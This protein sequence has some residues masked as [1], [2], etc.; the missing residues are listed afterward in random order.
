M[1]SD[2]VT[3]IFGALNKGSFRYIV[4]RNYEKYPFE[5]GNDIDILLHADDSIAAIKASKEVFKAHS[6][7]FERLPITVNGFLLKG[8]GGNGEALVIHFQYW[9]SLEYTY[10]HC[11]LPGLSHKI[12]AQDV[13]P[14]HRV[15]NDCAFYIGS[16]VDRF[17]LLLRQWLFKRKT[18]YR[19]EVLNLQHSYGVNEFL[20]AS[21]IKLPIEKSAF[22]S[23]RFV[24]RFLRKIAKKRWGHSPFWHRYFKAFLMV[25]RFKK[26]SLFA[27]VIY[28]TGPDGAGKTSVSSILSS[29]FS[30]Q[31]V[32]VKH[33]YSVKRNLIRH[34]VFTIRRRLSGRKD[35][36]FSAN[37]AS[38]RFRFI[39]TEDITDRNDGSIFWKMRKF[40]TLCI[41]I[42][43]V[44]INF[45]PVQFFR[46]KYDVVI[47]ETSPY[48]IFIKYHMP[49]FNYLEEVFS[50]L[51]PKASFGL[52]L[53]AKPQII[54]NRKNE[55]TPVEI[56]HYYHRLNVLLQRANC[57]TSFYTVR[58]DIDM[59]ET[60]SEI[61]RIL[62]QRS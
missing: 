30:E 14:V 31:G 60:E 8:S 5:I 20:Q 41:S 3:S 45:I 17:A 24:K 33:V 4:L 50:P 51:F 56:E 21:G 42:L 15:Q 2:V 43:D 25:I 23:D 59:Q 62:D 38:R 55:L 46:Y 39:M 37:P 6:Y 10:L 16:D 13:T 52:L 49:E 53:K 12:F 28:I 29:R 61:Q 54:A 9:V 47:V 32:K 58:T 34:L 1:L 22:E 35:N 19:E 48:D 40:M 36:K 11:S 44:F 26:R 27:P 18:C 7:D 57:S